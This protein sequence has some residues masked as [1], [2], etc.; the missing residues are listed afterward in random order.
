MSDNYYQVLGVNEKA[1]Q[2]EIRKAYRGLQMKWHPDKNLGNPEAITMTQKLN[3]AYETLG[4]EQKRADYDRMKSGNPFINIGGGGGGRH[5]QNV[6]EIFSMFFG[7]APIFPFPQMHNMTG[8]NIHIF[9]N[10]EF[11]QV[12]Q[13]PPPIFKTVVIGMEQVQMGASISLEIDR[14]I[15]KTG[16]HEKETIQVTIPKGVEDNEIIVI[17]DKGNML[18][19]TVKGDVHI[20]VSIENNTLFKRAGL[21]LILE[22][23]ITLKEALCGFSFEITYLNGKSYTLNNARGNVIPPEYKKV[24]PNMGL[25]RDEQKGNMVIHFHIQFPEKLTEEQIVELEKSL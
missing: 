8:G 24:Y 23:N 25:T 13:K 4:D 17:K 5:P 10:G 21:D 7:G 18:N 6:D 14:C 11:V 12:L 20:V 19:D 16:A 9:H 15:M 1:S 3:E 22:K 2:E